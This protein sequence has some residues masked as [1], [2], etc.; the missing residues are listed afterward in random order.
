M[1]D[2][3]TKRNILTLGKREY[4]NETCHTMLEDLASNHIK[5][6]ELAHVVDEER[7]P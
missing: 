5:N 3:W 4:W 7:R 6:I 1:C 2:E